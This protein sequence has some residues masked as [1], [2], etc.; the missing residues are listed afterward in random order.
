M[1]CKRLLLPGGGAA[2]DPY[3]AWLDG[4]GGDELAVIMAER[5]RDGEPWWIE[6]VGDLVSPAARAA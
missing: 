1:G 6:R 4:P 3:L 2:P 5:E